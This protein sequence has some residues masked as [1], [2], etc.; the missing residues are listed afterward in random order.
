MI[1]SAKSVSTYDTPRPPT[2]R[3][4]EKK[5]RTKQLKA[6][7]APTSLLPKVNSSMAVCP[8]MTKV[9]DCDVLS[10]WSN[11][12]IGFVS[13][14]SRMVCIGMCAIHICTPSIKI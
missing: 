9:H 12:K 14:T 3:T 7:A 11:F 6:G 8:H 4:V 1:A 10:L 13:T 2:K 5:Q